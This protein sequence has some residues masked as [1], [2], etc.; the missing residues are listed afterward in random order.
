LVPCLIADV[1]PAGSFPCPAALD[2]PL[3]EMFLDI[4]A[5]WFL[6]W[7]LMSALQERCFLDFQ[8]YASFLVS[9][10]IPR[11]V[12]TVASARWARYGIG[13]LEWDSGRQ[14]CASISGLLVVTWGN[15][16]CLGLFATWGNTDNCFPPSPPSCY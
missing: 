6:A 3:C 8:E 11:T 1:R 7:L 2:A 14:I 5:I 4:S 10:A 9:Q 16:G 12:V 13:M 15:R